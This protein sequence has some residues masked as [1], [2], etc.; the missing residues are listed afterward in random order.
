MPLALVLLLAWFAVSLVVGPLIGLAIGA[1]PRRASA[2]RAR[3][4][5]AEAASAASGA[6][7]STALG[8]A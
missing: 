1:G 2:T 6:P 3:A 4:A 8:A 7:R 5:R